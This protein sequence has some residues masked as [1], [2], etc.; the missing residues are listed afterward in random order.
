MSKNSF[1]LVLSASLL[2]ANSLAGTMGPIT[3]QPNWSWV[4]TF[5]AGPVWQ[6]GGATQ[7]FYL[8]PEIEKTYAANQSTHALFDGEV[9]VGLQKTLS[10]T[11]QGQ[12]GLAVAATSNASLT[13]VIWDDAD[14]EF[15][16]YTYSYKLQHTHVAVK[17]KLLADAGHWL[18][19]WVSASLGVGFNNAHSFNNTPLI[20]EALPN[21]DFSSHMTTAFTYTLG[22]G[23]QKALSIHWQVGACYEFADWGQSQ[24]QRVPGQTM[25][26]GLGLNHLYTNGLLLNLTYIT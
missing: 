4:G 14:P 21:A 5:S 1:V 26:S 17:G 9:F 25:G 8:I 12:L 19:P 18:T 3:Q 2:T 6:N 24:L 16:N 15:A 7:T 10:Q 23:V 11:L 20:F 13:G 22:V